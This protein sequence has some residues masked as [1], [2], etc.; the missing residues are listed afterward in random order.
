MEKSPFFKAIFATA[1]LGFIIL[2]KDGKIL[3][4]NSSFYRILR[5]V[6]KNEENI[7][8]Y[9]NEDEKRS[10]LAIYG[11]ITAGELSTFIMD[12]RHDAEAGS[13]WST[14]SVSR[15]FDPS[16]GK[17]FLF[18]IVQDITEQKEGQEKLISEKDEAEKLTRMKSEFL[19]NM[20]HEIR[21]PIHTMIGMN[22][23]LL[24]T[25]LDPEQQEYAAQIRF[26]AEVLL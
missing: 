14:L 1:P 22:E 12:V 3:Y 15:G 20:S 16:T 11:K 26:S 25:K 2:G 18:G 17:Q 24:E 23:L 8:S 10:F 6:G 5:N 4:A 7:T 21:T 13:V 9:L 19:A